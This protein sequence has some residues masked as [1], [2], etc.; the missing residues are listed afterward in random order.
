M[1]HTIEVLIGVLKTYDC[2]NSFPN[3]NVTT[4][5]LTFNLVLEKPTKISSSKI[6]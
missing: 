6:L 4:E 1:V 2:K 3:K 5:V